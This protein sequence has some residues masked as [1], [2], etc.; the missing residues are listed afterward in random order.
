MPIPLPF[1]VIMNIGIVGAAVLQC[2]GHI[3]FRPGIFFGVTVDPE[4]R[5]TEDAQR[6]LWRYRRP[7]IVGAAVCSAALWLVVPRLRGVAAPFAISGLIFI[8]IGVAIVSMAATT[9]H[10][11]PFAKPR[12]TTRTVSLQPRHRTLPGGWLPFTGPMLIVAATRL[13]LFLRRD[14]IPPQTYQ[15]ASTLLF[16]PFVCN[17]LLMWAAWWALFR[18]RQINIEGPAAAAEDADR[19]GM[20]WLRLV[21]AYVFTLFM[22]ATNSAVVR[23]APPAENRWYGVILIS[24]WVAFGAII[25]ALVIRKQKRALDTLGAAPA[26]DSTPDECWKFGL[27]YYNP[28][29][30]ALVVET[31]A[32]RFGSDLN[33]G[34]KQSW[35]VAAVILAAP[36][37]I[38]LFWF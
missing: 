37:V 14:G 20:Y 8:E 31:R 35:V 7:I 21:I 6:I 23:P 36:F 34:N 11:R 27:F 24:L 9:R 17:A 3:A 22:I 2:L 10:V 15:S 28:D 25:A 32:G 19:R 4:F 5:H 13:L 12:T 16:V 26:G 29:D 38:R 18:T 30:P 1:L 33:W